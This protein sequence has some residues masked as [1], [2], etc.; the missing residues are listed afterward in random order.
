MQ[1]KVE[2]TRVK[3]DVDLGDAGNR[4]RVANAAANRVQ[5]ARAALGH[6]HVAIGKDQQ[7]ERVRNAA[8]DQGDA[9]LLLRSLEGARQLGKRE[10]SRRTRPRRIL[11]TA[12]RSEGDNDRTDQGTDQAYACGHLSDDLKMDL[13]DEPA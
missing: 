7:A 9:H 8:S 3:S 6:E 10:P 2:K 5:T 13:A 12:E 1:R 4:L 11:G